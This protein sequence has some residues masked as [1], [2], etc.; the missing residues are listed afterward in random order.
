MVDRVR[1]RRAAAAG[2]PRRAGRDPGGAHERQT[3][4]RA[5]RARL[6]LGAVQRTIPIPRFKSVAQAERRGACRMDRSL[7]T[8]AS[9][10]TRCSV[11]PARLLRQVAEQRQLQSARSLQ[12]GIRSVGR[13][14]GARPM[15][16]RARPGDGGDGRVHRDRPDRLVDRASTW[17][18][19]SSRPAGSGTPPGTPRI[20]GPTRSWPGRMPND[21]RCSTCCVASR[22]SFCR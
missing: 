5:R 4:T 14:W 21:V 9:E 17:A 6:D 8:N 22:S 2:V 13:R 16:Q 3:H 10:S 18:D 19:T 7:R 1:R 15:A 11:A 20:S 12:P